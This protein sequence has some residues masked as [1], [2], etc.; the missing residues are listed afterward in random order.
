M[1]RELARAVQDVLWRSRVITVRP[2]SPAG[3]SARLPTPTEVGGE[4]ADP[5]DTA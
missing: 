4:A 1:R 5:C 3:S 2:D